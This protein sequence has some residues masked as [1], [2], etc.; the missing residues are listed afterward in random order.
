MGLP[1]QT[2]SGGLST[3][4]KHEKKEEEEEEKIKQE[5]A[6]SQGKNKLISNIL[7]GGKRYKPKGLIIQVS[8]SYI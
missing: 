4:E 2:G 8:Q 5:E 3:I 1:H 7:P 6:D